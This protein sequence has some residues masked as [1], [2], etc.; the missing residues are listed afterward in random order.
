MCSLQLN[1]SDRPGFRAAILCSTIVFYG[2]KMGQLFLWTNRVDDELRDRFLKRFGFEIPESLLELYENL[3]EEIHKFFGFISLEDIVEEEERSP[4]MMPGLVP[5]AKEENGD[6][7]C[8]YRSLQEGEPVSIG[9]WMHETNHFLPIT[10]K[11]HLFMHWWISKETIDC[12]GDEDWPEIKKILE[13]VQAS[14][15]I[16]QFDVFSAPAFYPLSWHQ[17]M[18]RLDPVNPFT[19]TFLSATQFA[20]LGYD[21]AINNLRNSQK[22][23]PHYGAPYIWEAR[24]QAMRG[25]ISEAHH[26]Y[27]RHMSVPIFINGYHYWWQWGDLQ[28]PELSEVESLSFMRQAEISPPA[29]ILR[30]RKIEMLIDGDIEDYSQRM[31]LSRKLLTEGDLNASLA[32]MSNALFLAAWDGSAMK[33]VL[34]NLAELYD[35]A[36]RG[37]ERD[38]CER[39][40]HKLEKTAVSV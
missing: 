21:A 30:K 39:A 10:D 3:P 9:V 40:T 11:M 12:F 18:N 28:I 24:L 27:W 35:R 37:C 36:R 8:F 5:F 14:C 2:G 26:A 19:L 1:F 4:R 20:L 6:R 7:F 15:G 32:E 29:E 34:P 23:M 22:V 13:I 16:E 17:E 31:E 33:K 25:N 38:Q